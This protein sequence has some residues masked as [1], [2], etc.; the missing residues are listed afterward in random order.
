MA[1][2]RTS[3]ITSA[4][5]PEYAVQHTSSSVKPVRERQYEEEP[6]LDVVSLI[7]AEA[8]ALEDSLSQWW[9][10]LVVRYDDVHLYVSLT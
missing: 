5:E 10:D 1:S 7:A 2:R 4:L 3:A 6:D 9:Q 8:A